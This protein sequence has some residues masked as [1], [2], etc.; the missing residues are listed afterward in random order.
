MSSVGQPAKPSLRLET[1]LQRLRQMRRL[2][3]V[4]WPCL[5]L[6]G[7]VL[8]RT[9]WGRSCIV[10]RWPRLGRQLNFSRRL[11][12]AMTLPPDRV[13]RELTQIYQ[14]ELF[15]QVLLARVARLSPRH[16]ARQFEV[17]GWEYL[18]AE[19]VAGRPVIL[20]GSHFGVNRL[21]SFWLAR[22]GVEV[23]SLVHE[24]LVQMMGV[25][26]P[27]TLKVVEIGAGFTAETALLVMRH[28]RSGGCLQITGDWQSEERGPHS[29]QR[30]FR[31]LARR[32]PQGMANFSLMG[33]AAILPYFCTLRSGG[34]V[35]IEIRPPLRPPVPPAPP[36]SAA[37]EAQVE[38]IV[39]R[40][41]AVLEAEI[42]RSPGIQRWT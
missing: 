19:R 6:A 25:A 17:S 2:A 10:R 5:W 31:G 29:Y 9:R 1:R 27:A 37:R 7:N 33:G 11:F 15:Q 21:F 22:Q 8:C 28:L 39:H 20:G 35:R 14:N 32:Y 16:K 23:L 36:G 4:P 42:E 41:A 12:A 34:R 3:I 38:D 24:D 18:E 26:K 40:F 13:D 30:T